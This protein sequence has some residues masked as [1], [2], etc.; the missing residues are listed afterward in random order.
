MND[1]T[2]IEVDYNLAFNSDG[3]S[4]PCSQT[5]GWVCQNP[6]PAHDLWKVDPKFV[7][8]SENDYH[9]QSISP[10]INAGV[11]I[12]SVANDY[13]GNSRPQ[14]SAPDIGAYEYVGAAPPDTTPP[15]A[16][17]GVMVN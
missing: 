6:P 16:P 8:P 4:P 2:G 14:G 1:A 13:D 11:T 5:V 9:L 17:T 12:S 7:N 15:A 3:S 10:A